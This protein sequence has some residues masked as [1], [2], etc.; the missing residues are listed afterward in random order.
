VAE[1]T[2]IVEVGFLTFRKNNTIIVLIQHII[3]YNTCRII[4]MICRKIYQKDGE[5]KISIIVNSF[6]PPTS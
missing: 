2:T 4:A 1:E 5:I 3:Y 6:L